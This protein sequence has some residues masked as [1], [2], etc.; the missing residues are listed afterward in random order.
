MSD[1]LFALQM[2]KEGRDNFICDAHVMQ[3]R[4]KRKAVDVSSK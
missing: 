3:E 1:F 2:G 4:Q